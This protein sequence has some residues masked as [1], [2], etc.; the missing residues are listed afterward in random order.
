MF[1][2][3]CILFFR[4]R[5]AEPENGESSSERE[6]LLLEEIEM[7]KVKKYAIFILLISYFYCFNKVSYSITNRISAQNWWLYSQILVV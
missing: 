6:K 2:L 3:L 4:P 7:T 5:L 1:Y